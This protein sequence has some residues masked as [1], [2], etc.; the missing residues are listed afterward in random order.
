D[1]RI[2]FWAASVAGENMADEQW[3]VFATIT[4]R[5]QSQKQHTQTIKKVLAKSAGAH[6]LG[7]IGMGGANNAQVGAARRLGADGLI[8]VVLGEPKKFG[9]SSQQKAIDLIQKEGATL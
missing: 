8:G 5:W 6:K 9:L 7:K 4:Q 3:D 2:R 1:G